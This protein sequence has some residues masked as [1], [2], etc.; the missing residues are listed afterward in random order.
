MGQAHYSNKACIVIPSIRVHHTRGV[1]AVRRDV[2]QLPDRA[3]NQG[4]V[5]QLHITEERLVDT[6]LDLLAAGV[7][8]F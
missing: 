2:V 7:K 3:I 8:A 4:N 5:E 1:V 6:T